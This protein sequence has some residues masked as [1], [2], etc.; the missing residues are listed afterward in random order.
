MKKATKFTIYLGL[1]IVALCSIG[2]AFTFINDALQASG[3][4]G[5][6]LF[7]PYQTTYFGLVDKTGMIDGK[8]VWGDRHYWYFWMCT[9]LFTLSIV[10]VIIWAYCYWED[11]I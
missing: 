6:T 5:D 4:F 10:R 7:K 3:F 1:Y 2:I 8:Y 9:L 11:E